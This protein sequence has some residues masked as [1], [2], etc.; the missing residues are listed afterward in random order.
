MRMAP[1]TKSQRAA[2]ADPVGEEVGEVGRP[3]G[4]GVPDRCDLHGRRAQRV[5]LQPPAVRVTCAQRPGRRGA[6]R[7]RARAQSAR[8]LCRG[9]LSGFR[10]WGRGRGVPGRARSLPRGLAR[11]LG[12]GA[13]AAVEVDQDVRSATV[14][15]L[16]GGGRRLPGRAR[17]ASA[18]P[19]WGLGAQ[20]HSTQHPET[21]LW[22]PCTVTHLGS[23]S[24]PVRSRA[25]ERDR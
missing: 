18:E 11:A 24:G 23:A 10:V 9:G 14:D 7:G 12:G 16:G 20:R 5:H 2:G 1:K 25:P 3:H 8:G 17:A 22:V 13:G 21:R 19:Q 4:A 15:C 6:G